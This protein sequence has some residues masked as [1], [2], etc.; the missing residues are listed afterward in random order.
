MS[1]AALVEGTLNIQC[2]FKLWLFYHSFEFRSMSLWHITSN[3]S[4]RPLG[5]LTSL[6][7]GPWSKPYVL[8]FFFLDPISPP[9][10]TLNLATAA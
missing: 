2:K 6:L 5:S 3:R 1:H 4:N 10:Q 8:Q 9:G 7:P